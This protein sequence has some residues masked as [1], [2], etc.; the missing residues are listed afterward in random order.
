YWNSDAARL[1]LAKMYLTTHRSADC[2][3]LLDATPKLAVCE[4]QYLR[5][6]ALYNIGNIAKA[7][8]IIDGATSVYPDDSR[9]SILFFKR[10]RMRET[11][12]EDIASLAR[13]FIN[14]ADELSYDNADVLLYASQFTQYVYP[15]DNE[16]AA[17]LSKRLL[18]AWK[19]KNQDNAL[20]AVFALQAS[21]LSQEAALDYFSSWLQGSFDEIRFSVL[22]KF[23]ALLTDDN[24]CTRFKTLLADFS[25]RLIFDIH[26][27]DVADMFVQYK[28]GRPQ[29]ITYDKN[30]DGLASWV[31]ECDYGVPYKLFLPKNKMTVL[32]GSWPAVSRVSIDQIQYN[33]IPDMLF[34][35]PVQIQEVFVT[36]I[37]SDT[38]FFIPVVSELESEL[39]ENQLYNTANTIIA[40]TNE[41]ENGI[42]R[43][44][45]LRG[46]IQNATW[47]QD[48]QPYAYGM[49]DN[50]ILQFR[51]VDFN[52]DGYYELCEAYAY[53][54]V[55]IDKYE[56]LQ[57][58]L[59][60]HMP[61]D[62]CA[63]LDGLY[64]SKIIV[65]NDQNGFPEYTEE[66]LQDGGR[67]CS[68][69]SKDTKNWEY[70]YV[71][72]QEQ[73]SMLS[74]FR[75]P[76][77]GAVVEIYYEN[78]VPLHVSDGGIIK[79]VIKDPD[80]DFYWIGQ[81]P[82]R[83]IAENLIE[84]LNQNSNS[85]VYTVI[86]TEQKNSENSTIRILAVSYGDLYFAEAFEY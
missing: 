6:K 8:S 74:R 79:T 34:W 60:G 26:K 71:Q 52:T 7:H 14:Q 51:N 84:S 63:Q 58:G 27:D 3:R 41:R 29:T 2:M 80:A 49:F 42:I 32:Y 47:I 76:Q 75:K 22:K 23:F 24:L 15:E 65:D 13:K 4:A 43:F 30:Q 86:M 69:Y 12:S 62:G 78:A 17:E 81:V 31:A 85:D 28:K 19:A 56:P 36:S 50:G 82:E 37:E 67:L 59:F 83:G 48:G 25:G 77:T 55:H 45:L 40:P 38:H 39:F 9:F 66:L 73:K 35:S 72:Y 53:D 64:L 33:L 5:A 61:A 44:T 10:E 21:M 18:K 68:W 57:A 70:Q 54:P 1:L 20:Y 11:V 16:A 46:V